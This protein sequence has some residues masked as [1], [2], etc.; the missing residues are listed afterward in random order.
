MNCSINHVLWSNCLFVEYPFNT[1]SS[2]YLETGH[3]SMGQLCQFLGIKCFTDTNWFMLSYAIASM[4]LKLIF[5]FMNNEKNCYISWMQGL[6]ICLWE[7]MSFIE[8]DAS[9]FWRDIASLVALKVVISTTFGVPSVVAF[10]DVSVLVFW[11]F[12]TIL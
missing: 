11:D 4:E 10:D 9:F 1:I 5:S 12:R 2:A 8:A 7:S 6:I 3:V